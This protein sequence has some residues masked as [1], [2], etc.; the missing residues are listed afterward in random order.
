MDT[1]LSDY[2]KYLKGN[3]YD[4][5]LSKKEK[6]FKYHEVDQNFDQEIINKYKN[7]IF[8]ILKN[9]IGNKLLI[10]T[11]IIHKYKNKEIYF[12]EQYSNHDQ[13][14]KSPEKLKYIF[15]NFNNN[16]YNIKI[17]SWK[18]FDFLKEYGIKYIEYTNDIFYDP[19]GLINISNSTRN[20]LK[21]NPKYDYLKDKYDLNNGIFVHYRLGDKFELNYKDCFK[22]RACQYALF[23]PKYY[24]DMINI[25]L[26]EKQGLIYIMSDSIK[27]AECLL[28]NKIP[29][30][31]FINEGTPETFF[32]MTHCNRLIIS[33]SSMTVAAAY[34]NNNNPQIIAPNFL[35]NLNRKII[36]NIYFD[37]QMVQFIDNKKYLLINKKQYDELYYKCYKKFIYYK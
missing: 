6:I 34:L 25:M 37:K 32:L 13:Y 18:L 28:K 5:I 36:K 23:T 19:S 17:I 27:V 30:L 21:M 16:D 3:S 33:E 29:N 1:I 22:K 7:G 14:D 8:V 4:D 35:I 12:L 26:K 20:L 10:I 31:I 2:F 15:P 24:I 9:G 11:N